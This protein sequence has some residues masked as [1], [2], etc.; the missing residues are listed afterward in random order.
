MYSN[1]QG[2]PQDYV[3]AARWYRKAADQ[4]DAEAQYGLGFMYYQGKG[5]PHDYVEAARWYRKAA[6]QDNAEADY[7]LGFMYLNGQ[8]F[9]RLCRGYP[10]VP[11]GRRSG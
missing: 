11:Q 10:L 2:V 1:G 6:E 9:R 4:G 8:G 3:E 7:G 5:V